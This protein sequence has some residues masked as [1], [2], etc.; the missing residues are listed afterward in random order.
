MRTILVLCLALVAPA[1]LAQSTS[2]YIE[3]LTWMEIRDAQAA[4][5]TSAIIYAGGTEQNGPHMALVKHN[6]IAQYAAG[7]IARKLGNALVYPIMPFSPAGD[8]IAK[9]GHARFPGTVSLSSEVFL[10]VMR[11]VALSAIAAGFKNVF[12]MGDHGG[13]QSELKLAAET[14]DA[15]WK[16]KGVRVFYVSDLQTRAGQQTNAY[17]AE[18]KIPGGGHAGVA[19]TSQVLFVEQAQKRHWIRR[20]KLTAA[21]GQP[22]PAT[23]INGD[24]S[25]ATSEMGRIF[26]DYKIDSAV[27]QIRQ[28]VAER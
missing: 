14:L 25:P 6:A 13:G 3:D 4:G 21:K 28:L 26:I 5:K 1:A 7:E 8:P 24:P 23:G 17:L 11:Q 27:D 12:L 20:D 22:E 19:E 9:T 15:D 16:P 10:G 2:V 18:H